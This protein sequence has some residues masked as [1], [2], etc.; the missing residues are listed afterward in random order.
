MRLTR[1]VATGF[2]V[3]LC[4]ALPV[5]A[6]VIVIPDH[7]TAQCTD[8]SWSM[9]ASQ[10]GACSSHGGV[11]HWMPAIALLVAKLWPGATKATLIRS[12]IRFRR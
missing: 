10:R 4:A 7:S 5:R 9:A 6:Q 2:A 11:K 12:A 1:L 8:G 3:A